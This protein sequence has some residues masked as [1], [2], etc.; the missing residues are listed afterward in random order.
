MDYSGN[1][2]LQQKEMLE[3]IGLRSIEELFQSIPEKVRLQSSATPR[4]RP[5]SEIEVVNE[6]RDLA[7]Q[8]KSALD[9][10]L[11]LGG[12]YYDHFVPA[13]LKFLIGRPEFYT[14]Y[15]PYQAEAS[16]GILQAI[17]EY[18][19]FIT[20]LT[21]MEAA[22]ASLYDGASALAEAALMAARINKRKTILVSQAIHPEYLSVLETYLSGSDLAIKRIPLKEGRVDSAFLK[23]S[24]DK[25]TSAVIISQPNFFGIF[26]EGERI[27]P[28]IRQNGS[29]YIV[30]VD[31]IALA[32]IRPPGEWGADIVVGEGQALGSGLNFGGPGLGFMASHLAFVRKMPGRLVG[33]TEDSLG[34]TGYVLTLQTRE[35][36]IRRA[37]AT[38][39]ICTNHALNAL[40]AT[41]YLA[42]LGKN[43]LKMVAG[44]CLQKAHYAARKITEI[45]GY[46]LKFKQPFFKEFVLSCPHPVEKINR[47]LL[48]NK[49]IGGLDLAVRKKSLNGEFENCMLLA[50]TE[51]RSKEEIDKL[52]EV[53]KSL[54]KL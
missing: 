3:A 4:A 45:P 24:L 14:A 33:Q 25:D 48:E 12:G 28:F 23:S 53:L 22:N 26:E 36:H 11:F 7:G 47:R 18:Q 51:K 44:L 20:L 34:R 19:T 42:L 15:T 46:K 50:V 2:P 1:T 40:A 9:Y 6:L 38:S 13:A 39:N 49:I 54:Q 17:Y 16:Q 43:G 52:I 31:P 35:Q 37:Q 32:M 8:N 10:P 27:A 41:I 21:G 29:L 30:S 5:L